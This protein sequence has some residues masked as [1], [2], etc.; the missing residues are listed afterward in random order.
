MQKFPRNM[1]FARALSNG[2]RWFCPDVFYG[3]SVY[4]E[5]EIGEMQMEQPAYIIVDR[6]SGEV[7]ESPTTSEP[8]APISPADDDNPFN[9]ATPAT[10]DNGN[11]NGNGAK[12]AKLPAATLKRLH[13]VGNEAYGKEWDTKRPELVKSVTKG[14][15]ESSSDLTQ[16]EASK[17]I[18]GMEKL[19]AK[20]AAESQAVPA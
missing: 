2:V 8:E 9:D 11:G 7:L 13:A 15:S 6:E 17:L 20:L 19:I 5:G 18:F 10:N 1:L 4:V 16:D 3:N 12:A 14:R